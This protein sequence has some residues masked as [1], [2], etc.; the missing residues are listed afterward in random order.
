MPLLTRGAFLCPMLNA[1][2][3]LLL[4]LFCCYW[5]VCQ[6]DSVPPPRWVSIVMRVLFGLFVSAIGLL[7]WL[8]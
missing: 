2:V 6:L 5:V 3:G 4:L 7:F 8:Y 1:I